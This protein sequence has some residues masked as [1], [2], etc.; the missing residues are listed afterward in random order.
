MSTIFGHGRLR[1]YLLKLLDESPKHGYEIISLLRDRFLGVYSPSPGTIYPRL[2]RLEEEGL[3]THEEVNGRK[4]YSLTD[5]GREELNKRTVDLDELEREIT[6]SVRDVARTVQRDV[7]DTISHLREELKFAAGGTRRTTKAKAEEKERGSSPA[8]ED[9]WGQAAGE[10]QAKPADAPREE[11]TDKNR[12]S[13]W[14]RDWEKLT[15]GLG[16]GN[17][18]PKGGGTGDRPDF[19]RTLHDFG[20]RVREVV[21]DAGHVGEA[22]TTD[23]RRI[24]DETIEVIRRDA[25]S[26]GP[27]DPAK[28]TGEATGTDGEEPETVPAPEERSANKQSE[29]GDVWERVAAEEPAATTDQAENAPFAQPPSGAPVEGQPAEKPTVD[30][31][32]PGPFAQPPADTGDAPGPDKRN[33]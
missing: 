15:Q 16:W 6:E 23:L 1:L 21:R 20:D 32:G 9:V 30:E 13:W 18:W 7:R 3:V 28:T 10:E 27:K 5:K 14:N 17:A 29:K 33:L 26:W 4:V 2:A 19:E 12:G 31:N 22:A 24:L 8:G 11:P 25:A